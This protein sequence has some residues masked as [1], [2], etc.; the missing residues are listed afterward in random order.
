MTEINLSMKRK[1]TRDT[2]DRLV[3]AKGEGGWGVHWDL[4]QQMQ[5]I[6][7]T[8]EKQG[9][10]RSTGGYAHCPTATIA[11]KSIK[12]NCMYGFINKYIQ[13]ICIWIHQ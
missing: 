9:L 8:V 2:E 13:S 6:T 11:E 12:K 3:T 10:L 4:G 7:Y 5:T 1:Q